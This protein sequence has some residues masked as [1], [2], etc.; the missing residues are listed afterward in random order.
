[1][2]NLSKKGK[3][4]FHSKDTLSLSSSGSGSFLKSLG[5]DGLLK[6][7]ESSG[8]EYLN[9][10]GTRDFNSGFCDPVR[11]GYLHHRKKDCIFDVFRRES[12]SI[13]N[14]SILED[15]NGYLDMYYPDES[16]A[17]VQQN[18]SL[19]PKYGITDLNAFCSYEFLEK[20]LRNNSA[21]IFKFRLKNK[22]VRVYNKEVETME[23]GLNSISFELNAFNL[24]KLTDNI[25]MFVTNAKETAIY[26]YGPDSEKWNLEQFMKK[27]KILINEKCLKIMKEKPGISTFLL[28]I[29]L[30]INFN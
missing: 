19:F 15:V 6:I 29:Y 23:N 4:Q 28:F 5:R 13:S 12:L 24:I 30:F 14:A 8:I 22:K 17:A 9:I 2:P 26:R 3:L 20:S 10:F 1:M 7:L 18:E 21:E 25:K 16:R 11:L 27:I